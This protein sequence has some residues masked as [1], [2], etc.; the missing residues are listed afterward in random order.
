MEQGTKFYKCEEC[1]SVVE[2]LEGES[3][4]LESCGGKLKEMKANTSEGAGEKHIPEVEVKGNMAIVKVG[5]VLHPMTEE[6]NI[7]WVALYTNE[8]VYRKKLE[9][10]KDPV[11]KFLLS[12]GEKVSA[13]Y[14]YCNQHGLWKK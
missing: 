3:A 4:P 12:E 11:V 2:L 9:P 8:G 10:G 14:A 1:G 5:S 7:G 13:V 6:H